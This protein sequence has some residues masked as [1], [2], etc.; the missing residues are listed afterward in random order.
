M[1]PCLSPDR[2]AWCLRDWPVYYS[3]EERREEQRRLVISLSA[4]NPLT[5]LGV[6]DVYIWDGHLSPTSKPCDYT[7]CLIFISWKKLLMVSRCPLPMRT[8]RCASCFP[9]APVTMI[10]YISLMIL[11]NVVAIKKASSEMHMAWLVR[12]NLANSGLSLPPVVATAST[13]MLRAM[14]ISGFGISEWWSSFLT[15]K[16]PPLPLMHL[17]PS[18]PSRRSVWGSG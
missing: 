13:A 11:A 9:G 16:W 4:I 18:N 2:S 10:T 15:G 8:I 6:S 17:F 5:G 1:G 3:P 7:I 14:K 12:C